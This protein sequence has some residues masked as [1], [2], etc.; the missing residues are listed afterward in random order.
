VWAGSC[1]RS[2][3]YRQNAA[4]ALVLAFA[5]AFQI[6]TGAISTPERSQK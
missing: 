5:I 6:L 3:G 4:L 2:R 1:F